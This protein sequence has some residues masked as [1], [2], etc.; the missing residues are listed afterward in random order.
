MAVVPSDV[1]GQRPTVLGRVDPAEQVGGPFVELQQLWI[2]LRQK[3]DRHQK[4]AQIGN[5][6]GARNSRERLMSQWQVAG[7]EGP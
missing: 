6:A 3:A 2:A 7:R 4:F 1:G 5:A